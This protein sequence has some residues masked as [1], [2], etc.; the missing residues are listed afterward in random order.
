MY[1]SSW[2]VLVM[3]IVLSLRPKVFDIKFMGKVQNIESSF[4]T[5]LSHAAYCSNKRSGIYEMCDTTIVINNQS[6]KS[7]CYFKI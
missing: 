1:N 4:V 3:K 7:A 6:N 5:M 2:K